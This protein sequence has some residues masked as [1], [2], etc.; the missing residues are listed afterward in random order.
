VGRFLT[1][2]WRD[3]V[4]LNYEVD[5]AVLSRFV[6][7]GTE[8]D[9]WRG[10]TF[11]SIVGFRFLRTRVLGVPIPFHRDFEEVN[12]RLYVRR[13]TRE[14]WSRG[15]VFVKEIVPRAAIAWIARA[16]Y[17]ENYVALPMRHDV[18]VS[19]DGGRVAYAWR[20]RGRW[21]SM[22]V[23]I[24][25]TAI[26]PD[27]DSH[28][29]FITEHYWGYARQADGS[30]LEYKVEHPRWRVWQAFDAVLDCDVA[31]LYGPAFVPLLQGR[32]GSAFVA[33]G[34]AVAVHRGTV[35]GHDAATG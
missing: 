8:L 6:P 18:A 25:G 15:V 3:L 24:R 21:S 30:S 27:A 19:D 13:K 20:H 4:M 31:A 26:L 33:D 9:A 35:L 2:E 32:P 5:P 16:V 11:V 34:S 1:A 28:E 7:E 12:L 14:G 17:N 10:M 23:S 29:A 22:T